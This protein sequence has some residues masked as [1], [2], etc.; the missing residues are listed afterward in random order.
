[1]AKP[2]TTMPDQQL[3]DADVNALIAFHKWVNGINTNGWPPAPLIGDSG[4]GA[5]LFE[6]KGCSTCHRLHG[7][8]EPE[9]GPD[10]SAIAGRNDARARVIAWL[11]DPKRQ[12][13]DTIMPR[14]E[15]TAGERAAL[16]AYMAE[17]H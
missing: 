12:N 2:G 9:P 11:E 14:P 13:P 15:L 4:S 17:R 7:R 16:V 10:L 5:L 1:M 8:G 3:T 6:Q